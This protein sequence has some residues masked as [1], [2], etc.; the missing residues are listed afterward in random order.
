[1]KNF[2]RRKVWVSS[3]LL[4]PNIISASELWE[5]FVRRKSKIVIE[6]F[7]FILHRRI[8]LHKVRQPNTSINYFCNFYFRRNDF[9]GTKTSDWQTF[10]LVKLSRSKL[11]LSEFSKTFE[12]CRRLNLHAGKFLQFCNFAVFTNF[13]WLEQVREKLAGKQIQAI[14]RLCRFRK[15]TTEGYFV[16]AK[17]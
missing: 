17:L 3:K 14:C 15:S 11:K 6:K 4:S 2:C 7:E 5:V 16:L 12:V 8:L 13:I 9:S 10:R 1:M